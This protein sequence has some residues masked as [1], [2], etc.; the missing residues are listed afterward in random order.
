MENNY[1]VRSVRVTTPWFGTKKFYQPLKYDERSDRLFCFKEISE[2]TSVWGY[3][4]EDEAW[5]VI[6][7]QI[8]ADY[9]A[10]ADGYESSRCPDTQREDF[11][12]DG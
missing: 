6:D 5:A 3:D 8:H 2:M 11:H 4:S 9:C 7:A 1:S 12:A 10:E